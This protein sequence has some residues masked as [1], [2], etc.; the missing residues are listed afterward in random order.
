MCRTLDEWHS[1]PV[2]ERWIGCGAMRRSLVMVVALVAGFALAVG[3]AACGGDDKTTTETETTTQTASQAQT[4]TPSQGGGGTTTSQG[5]GGA[6]TTPD[7]AAN[8]TSQQAYS[9]VSK[10]C[11]DV[12][13]GNNP[14]PQGQVPMAD[15][16]VCVSKDQ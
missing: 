5:G 4:T 10:S 15:Q 12:R 9:Q 13:Q 14:C 11:V 6:T 1:T 16:P 2:T 3:V 8:C 7:P